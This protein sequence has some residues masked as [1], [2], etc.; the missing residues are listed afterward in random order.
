MALALIER[1]R[2]MVIVGMC[3]CI[4]GAWYAILTAHG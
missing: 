2:T 4:G 1:L 3:A